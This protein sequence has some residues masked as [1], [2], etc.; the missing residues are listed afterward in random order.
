MV[1]IISTEGMYKNS[2]CGFYYDH[3]Y[4]TT[5]MWDFRSLELK[6]LF[7]EVQ[8]NKNKVWKLE[9]QGTVI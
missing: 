5:Q 2:Q 9:F 3:A 4:S 7:S 1:K 8:R 6:H